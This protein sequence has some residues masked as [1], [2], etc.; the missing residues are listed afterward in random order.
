MSVTVKKAPQKPAPEEKVKPLLL[1]PSFQIPERTLKTSKVLEGV[2]V[3]NTG[4]FSSFFGIPVATNF[5]EHTLGVPPFTT[6]GPAKYWRRDQVTLVLQRLSEY[7][8]TL[9]HML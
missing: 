1:P 4:D 7:A 8:G 5:I 9:K 6:L 3:V 2:E